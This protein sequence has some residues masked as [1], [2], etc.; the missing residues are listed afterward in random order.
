MTVPADV[1]RW[2]RA[3]EPGLLRLASRYTG[4]IDSA[5]DLVQDV[6]VLAIQREGRFGSEEDFQRWARARIRWFALDYLR[7]QRRYSSGVPDTATPAN[8]DDRL[9]AEEIL[10]AVNALP[11]RQRDVVRRMIAGEEIRAIAKALG[12]AE[13]TVRSVQRFARQ[14]LRRILEEREK[15]S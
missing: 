6:A 15:R 1:A 13:A 9:A 7:L 14:S 11:N 12:I 2:W 4:S 5:R 8:V 10:I 3:A